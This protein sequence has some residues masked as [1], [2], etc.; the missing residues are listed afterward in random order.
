MVDWPGLLK[1]S[2]QFHDQEATD[3]EKKQ[4]RPMDNE[5]RQWLT[6]AMK[7][8]HLDEA[9]QMDTIIKDL[10]THKDDQETL[11]SLLDRLDEV[12]EGLSNSLDFCTLGGMALLLEM[13]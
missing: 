2:T 3:L 1:W 6:E 5:R 12:L 4:M 11:L 7:A 10:K 13:V 9:D 8:F